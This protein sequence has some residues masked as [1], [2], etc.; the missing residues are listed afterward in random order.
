MAAFRVTVDWME[1]VGYSTPVSA[2]SRE[3]RFEL[4]A[5]PHLNDIF[6]SASRIVGDRTRA[7][8]V[9]Q[10]VFLQA[11]KSFHRF[12]S[13]TNCRAWLFQIL[14]HCVHHQR[15]KWFR[16]P[17]LKEN[18]EFIE[19]NLPYMPPVSEHLTDEEI[20]GA[21]DGISA[22]YREV[23]LLVDVEEFSYKEAAGILSIPIGT[24]MSRLNRGRRLLRQQLSGV[25]KSYG[26]GRAAGEGQGI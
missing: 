24:V 6:R 18:E 11:W 8:D 26:I 5:M 4:E 14:F 10:E 9:A 22:D 23:I 21:L 20:L 19:A 7:Q 16:F 12:Q 17:L 25:A 15:R 3:E 13:G 1:E 2:A